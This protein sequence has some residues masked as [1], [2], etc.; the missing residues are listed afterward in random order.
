MFDPDPCL[1][2]GDRQVCGA[3]QICM[4]G[5][6]NAQSNCDEVAEC[7]AGERRCGPEGVQQCS[8]VD[9]CLLWGPADPCAEGLQCQNGVC[10]DQSV[11]ECPIIGATAC[12][13]ELLIECGQ[14]DDDAAL[15]WSAGEPCPNGQSCSNGRC[16][17]RAACSDECQVDQRRC[18]G[19]G[20]EGCV[21]T[22]DDGCLEFGGRQACENG[23]SCSFG[24][25]VADCQDECAVGETTCQFGAL[26]ICGEFD[27]DACTDW[28]LAVA[29]PGD[30]LCLDLRCQDPADRQPGPQPNPIN[31]ITPLSQA[32]VTGTQI[33]TVE[34]PRHGHIQGTRIDINGEALLRQDHGGL[35]SARW[36]TTTGPDGPVTITVR[37][38]NCPRRMG[39]N[40]RGDCGQHGPA[41]VIEA[42][43]ATLDIVPLTSPCVQR[44]RVGSRTSD[45]S[46]TVKSSRGSMS[47]PDGAHRPGT[48][49][50]IAKDLGGCG[51]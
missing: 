21:D 4:D 44:T 13:G 46:S 19:L 16:A 32:R 23:E 34:V 48:I 30:Q 1:D 28:S 43:Q 2:W 8:E 18:R 45:S 50:T 33:V 12:L 7:V 14:F 39:S 51:A 27:G 35:L 49:S 3:Q 36:D 41:I 9:G 17:E 5:E 31:I 20:V 37:V 6:C 40:S 24:D 15:D 47:H 26:V 22:D 25:C 29:C 11:D 38:D 42:P 10:V